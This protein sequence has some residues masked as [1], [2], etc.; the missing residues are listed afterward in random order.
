MT[1]I[2]A[3]TGAM[4]VRHLR[5]LVRQ[6]WYIAISLVQPVIWL[7]LFGALFERVVDVPGFGGGDYVDFLVPGV[8]AMTALFSGGW[9]GMSLIDDYDQGVLDRFLVSPARRGSLIG[10]PIAYQAV[11]TVVQ[12]LI[13]VGL[14]L[15][16][17]A[18]IPGGVAGVAVLIGASV[19]LA[20]AFGGLSCAVGLLARQRETLI[21]AVQLV[22]LPLTFLSSGLMRE[23]LLPGW[24]Q[25]VA[26]YNPANWAV[27]AGREAMSADVDW[28]VVL[29]RCGL[30]VAL[31][32]VSAWLA[33]RA[34]RAYQRSL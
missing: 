27:V 18:D 5:I 26:T 20:A 25:D 17:G 33:T 7:L 10:G 24:V 14:A 28:G 22:I 12:S 6:P 29:S 8:V 3:D 23:D 19:L 2:L 31:A 9:L 21:G 4:T 16:V 13:V 15:A 11:T 32:A 30:L 34:F 1:A